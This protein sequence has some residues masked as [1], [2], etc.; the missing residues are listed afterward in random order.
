MIVDTI[1]QTHALALTLLAVGAQQALALNNGFTRP[2]MG[3]MFFMSNISFVYVSFT[4]Y[5]TGPS[6]SLVRAVAD[7][8]VSSG[9]AAAGY[10]YV[11]IDDCWQASSRASDGSIVADPTR[12][13]NGM[14]AVSDYVHS[15]GLK[16][17]LYSSAGTKTCAGYPAG[18]G[19]EKKDATVYAS[20]GVDY[21]KYD[22]CY[23]N[24]GASKDSNIARYTA[25][26]DALNSTGR[27]IYYSMCNWGQA[28]PWTFAQPIA[29]SWRITG[30]I[31]DLF[32]SSDYRCPCPS[33]GP[34]WLV[35][36]NGGPNHCSVMN[37][38]DSHAAF[39]TYTS[40]GGY[41]DLDIL[42]VGNGGMNVEEYRTHF[43]MWSAVKSPLMLG[44]D[45][46]N[47]T[48][49]ILSILTNP[50]IIALNQV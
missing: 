21:L 50:E 26:R 9:L 27:P 43:T 12:F 36:L 31:G 37:I 42:E 16:F 17:G 24:N 5:R 38:L 34:C 35:N 41:N 14:K 22:N 44:N 47:V 46:T 3:W 7:S 20:W 32:D 6:D 19:N 30:D 18:L 2:P 13:P 4:A 49:D 23:N 39:A 1:L 28:S 10:Q 8:M 29:N 33:P 45:I 48:A 25:M 11:N 40:V 15:K